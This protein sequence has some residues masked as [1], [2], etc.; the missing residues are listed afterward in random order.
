MGCGRLIAAGLGDLRLAR[1]PI[2]GALGPAF[3]GNGGRIP[4]L[5]EDMIRGFECKLMFTSNPI[6]KRS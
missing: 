2:G 3:E 5:E 6:P 1:R 4:G